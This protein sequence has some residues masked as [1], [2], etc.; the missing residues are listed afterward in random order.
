MSQSHVEGHVPIVID[1]SVKELA[2]D[3]TMVEV[4]V[5]EAEEKV[6]VEVEEMMFLKAKEE[7]MVDMGEA[8]LEEGEVVGEVLCHLPS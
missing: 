7:I 1:H 3:E 4:V 8:I 2:L 5:E 6:V